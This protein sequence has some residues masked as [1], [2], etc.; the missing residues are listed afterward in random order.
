MTSSRNLIPPPATSPSSPLSTKT[1][2]ATTASKRN[3]ALGRHRA[4]AAVPVEI[5]GLDQG[6][7]RCQSVAGAAKSRS[8]DTGSA[9][10]V[11]A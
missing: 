10:A 8:G 6:V 5:T 7:E 9:R 1:S 11:F 4:R 2:A 3:V